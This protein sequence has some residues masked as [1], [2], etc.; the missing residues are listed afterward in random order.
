MAGAVPGA[1]TD[2]PPTASAEN[3]RGQ[4]IPN[5]FVIHSSRYEKL[6]LTKGRPVAIPS[7]LTVVGPYP[8][9]P[10]AEP[11]RAQVAAIT[12]QVAWVVQP[13]PS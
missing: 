5:V 9:A 2:P 6:Q 4:N 1:I 11:M 3:L 8:N 12:K 10:A 13:Q 7:W